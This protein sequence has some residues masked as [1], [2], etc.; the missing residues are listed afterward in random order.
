MKWFR[1]LV[2]SNMMITWRHAQTQQIEPSTSEAGIYF[3][4]VGTISSPMTWKVVSYLNLQPNR[5]LWRKVKDHY[6]QVVIYCQRLENTTW[7]HHKNCKSF[8]QYVSPK[9]KYIVDMKELVLEYSKPDQQINRG[10]R[11][12]LNFVGEISRILFGTLTQSDAKEY[13]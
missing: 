5:D 2:V 11:G 8:G 6:K 13:N 4:E 12:V 1:L 7:Y 3:D 10:K 9:T